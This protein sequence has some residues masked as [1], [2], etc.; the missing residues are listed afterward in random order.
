MATEIINMKLKTLKKMSE[1]KVDILQ[2]TA[3]WKSPLVVSL[4]VTFSVTDE[5]RMYTAVMLIKL[6]RFIA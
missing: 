4:S 1:I 5:I 2:L 6:C 3:E